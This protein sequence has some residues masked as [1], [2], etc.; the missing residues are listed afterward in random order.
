MKRNGHPDSATLSLHA[1]GDLGWFAAW[2]TRRHAARCGECRDEIAAFQGMREILPELNE[3]PELNWNRIAGE[4]RANIRLGLAA[5]ECVRE[6]VVGTPRFPLLTG[7]R[8][9][10]AM[11]GVIALLVTGLVLERPVPSVMSAS[12]PVVQAT[13]NGIERRA[14]DQGFALMHG[15]VKVENVTYSV[16]AQGTMGASYVDPQTNLVT[17]TKVYVE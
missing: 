4:M 3:L 7:F 14:G 17:V 10:L 8:T 12:V 15:G 2:R 1:G 11:A 13:R 16:G 6:G 5:G 9:A